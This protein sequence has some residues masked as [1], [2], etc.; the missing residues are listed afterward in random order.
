MKTNFI[1]FLLTLAICNGKISDAKW[2]NQI[3][4]NNQTGGYKVGPTCE[5]TAKKCPGSNLGIV[6]NQF[7]SIS[8]LQY[9]KD[10]VEGCLW[11]SHSKSHNVCILYGDGCNAD[12]LED[13]AEY[14][15][16]E[17]SCLPQCTVHNGIC[18]GSADDVDFTTTD[19]YNCLDKCKTNEFCKWIS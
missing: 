11:V 14:S 10:N 15:T 8:C 2:S 9:C 17:L 18:E 13:N 6:G 3:N 4:F 7:T 16:S 1:F 5:E 12:N 19:F